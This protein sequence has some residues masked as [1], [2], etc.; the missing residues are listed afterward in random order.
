MSRVFNTFVNQNSDNDLVKSLQLETKLGPYSRT[1][2]SA[3]LAKNDLHHIHLHIVG[4]SFDKIHKITNEL[5]D[6]LENDIDKLAELAM[7]LNENCPNFSV[8]TQLLPAWQIASKDYYS[9]T[10]AVSTIE[11]VIGNYIASLKELRTLS[12]SRPDIQSLL[13]ELIRYWSK[14]L[15]FKNKQRLNN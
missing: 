4:E 8:A 6:S 3:V 5:Y 7:E 2:C 9:Y 15:N 1:L 12:E 10:E 13:D 14:E 11:V